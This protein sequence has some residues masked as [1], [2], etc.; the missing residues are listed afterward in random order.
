[1]AI[2]LAQGQ[3]LTISALRTPS[4]ATSLPR[5]ILGRPTLG[6]ALDRAGSL[7][8]AP[9][10]AAKTPSGRDRGGR[11]DRAGVGAMS[12]A[13]D[14]A[15]EM[16]RYEHACR[17]ACSTSR[18]LASFR[19]RADRAAPAAV[20]LAHAKFDPGGWWTPDEAGELAMVV[21]CAPPIAFTHSANRS[22]PSKCRLDCVHE[23]SARDLGMAPRRRLGARRGDDRTS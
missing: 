17:A 5:G 13:D 8:A 16:S 19:P 2:S 20:G 21:A 18:A 14:P 11:R 6:P 7:P 15:A 10:L 12:A 9:F 3:R 22:R 4:L 23:Q 1:V